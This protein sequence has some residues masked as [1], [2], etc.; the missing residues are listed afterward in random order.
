[1]SIQ[2]KIQ[3]L[4]K[5]EGPLTRNEIFHRLRVNREIRDEMKTVLKDL[6]KEGVLVRND[7]KAYEVLEDTDLISGRIQGNEK[8]YGFL[9]PDD[10]DMEDVYIH[11][12]KMNTALHGDR[13][14]VEL[15]PIREGDRGL[16]GIVV[17]VLERAND[18]LVGTFQDVERFGFVV[19]DE[20][21]ISTDIYIPKKKMRGA[22]NRQKVLVKIDKWP[23]K[24]KK[25]EGQVLEVL[26]YPDEKGVDILSIALGQGLSLEFP[27]EVLYEAEAMPDQ[28][29]QGQRAG[30]KDFTQATVFTID[31]EDSKDFDDAVSISRLENGHYQLGVHIADVAEYVREGSHLDR[32][33]EERG[34][35][36]YLISEVIPMLP[37]ELSNGICSLNEGE[38]RLTLSVLMEVDQ[39]GRVVDHQIMESVIS[40]KRRLVYGHVSDFLEGKGKDKSL[41]G[42]EEDLK[43]MADLAKILQDKRRRRGSIDFNFKE[44]RIILD[45][46]GY[47]QDIQLEDRRVANKLIE[48]FMILTN[49][50]I[51]RHFFEEEVPFLYRVHGVPDEDRIEDLN[52][53]MRPFGYRIKQTKEDLQPKTIQALLDQVKGKDEAEL[54]NNLVLRSMQKARYSE[55]WD[56]HFGLASTYYSHFTAP[57]RR[58][59]DLV[60]HRIVK[61]MI[62]GTYKGR[63]SQRYEKILPDIADHVSATEKLAQDTERKVQDVKMA[64]YMLDHVYEVYEGKVS[65][66]T[67]FGIFVELENTVEGLVS[68]QSMTGFY[69]FDPDR[70][71]VLGPSGQVA[72]KMGQKVKVEVVGADPIKGTIDFTLQGD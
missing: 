22:K 57:I 66:L 11:G 37:E 38:D 63:M 32:E 3:K 48:E 9:I 67:S 13:V 12:T 53:I 42:L 43:L 46:Q 23:K 39:K 18:T 69:Q 29:T 15:R 8:G 36:V 2:E 35:S 14:L 41:K 50:V 65:G 20:S 28:V 27:Q 44:A 72:F 62:N 10:P 34:N 25:P 6:V 4:I 70:Y 21:R 30:R 26:G 19:P 51:G 59:N 54:I 49:E 47:P 45:D 1:M 55:D 5:E 71:Q 33:A 52:G 40:S 68:Y 17:Q 60:I 31:G 64:Q 56:A 61:A 7:N 58:Y 16:E 24:K